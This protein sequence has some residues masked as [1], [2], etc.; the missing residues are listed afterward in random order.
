MPRFAANITMLYPDLPFLDRFACAA[1][2]GFAAVEFFFPYA[3]APADIA[4]RLNDNGLELV[5]FDA[6]PRRDERERGIACLP[7]RVQEFRQDF[8][9]GLHYA[10]ALNCARL[11]VM[12]GL[13]PAGAERRE[14]HEVYVANLA[15]AAEQAQRCGRGIQIEPINPLDVPGFFLTRQADAH[16]IVEEV[17]AP[18][19]KVQMDLYHCQRVE[20][21]PAELLRRYL[22]T[23]RVGHIQVSNV[24][25]RH[26]PEGGEMDYPELFSLID[27]LGF[28][29]W[30]AAEYH[31]RDRGPGGTSAGLAWLRRARA[32][33]S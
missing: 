28:D 13:V 16:A 33:A 19:L 2:D 26:E 4:A 10:E 15:W 32:C 23:G 14:L 3:H 30:T 11:H 22:P 7:D 29:G 5:L 24:P 21:N 9:Q 18:N 31:P 6:T 25:G 17:G 8:Q 12:A 27:A 1:R 20:G